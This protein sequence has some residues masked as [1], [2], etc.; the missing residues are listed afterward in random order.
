[1]NIVTS[2]LAIAGCLS[3]AACAAAQPA[4]DNSGGTS[5]SEARTVSVAR[6]VPAEE[7][8][9]EKPLKVGLSDGYGGNAWRQISLEVIRAEIA[10]CPAVDG[11]VLY[12]NANG[13]QQKAA[14]DINGLVSQGVDVLIVYPD[15]GPAQIPALRAATRAGVTVI[16]YDGDPGGTPGE[17]YTA[18]IVMGTEAGGQDLG[19]WMVKT[20]G[21]GNIV[22][23]GGIAGAPTSAQLLD[24]I[25][26]ALEGQDGVK[27]V[28]D[29]P[30]TTNWNKVD[31]QKAVS[32]LIA[33][34]PN[35][36]GVITDYGVTAAAAIDAFA[37]AKVDIPAIASL[38]TSNEL[39]CLWHTM[40]DRGQEFPLFSVDS[41]NDMA[42]AAIRKGIAAAN[43]MET[44]PSEVFRMPVFIDSENGKEPP[45]VK[46]LPLDA[47]LS[48]PLDEDELAAL[49]N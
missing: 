36:D 13:D 20:L 10:K 45:C 3:L 35:I 26:S 4:A 33:K 8:C 18:K 17:D 40:R 38:A 22:F 30:V 12:T 32:G 29:E 39:G 5:P 7:W 6:D 21:T 46:D 19:S 31:A 25:S 27:L 34:Y 23:L 14:S 49:F 1:M 42:Q 2:T 47:D 24:G 44:A 11:E 41:T 15:F 48:S 16:P 43:G 9:G 37:N 28:V